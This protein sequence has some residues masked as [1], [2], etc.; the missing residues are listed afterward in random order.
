MPADVSP[1]SRKR[2]LQNT[3]VLKP[4]L[5]RLSETT[6]NTSTCKSSQE[7]TTEEIKSNRTQNVQ[8]EKEHP[9]PEKRQKLVQETEH[10][11][12][13]TYNN[14]GSPTASRVNQSTDGNEISSTSKTFTSPSAVLTC[15]N[16]H[17]SHYN[18]ISRN[19]MM[20]SP[21][22]DLVK[23]HPHETRRTRFNI[24]TGCPLQSLQSDPIKHQYSPLSH[25]PSTKNSG[26][27]FNGRDK[28]T[29]VGTSTDQIQ[30]E[31]APYLNMRQTNQ[32]RLLPKNSSFGNCGI[33]HGLSTYRT[34]YQAAP[35]FYSSSSSTALPT[36]GGGG[37]GDDGGGSWDPMKYS[38]HSLSHS[39]RMLKSAPQNSFVLPTGNDNLL[40]G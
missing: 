38:K 20:M 39:V 19:V 2:L 21:N 32:N 14:A 31:K 22:C 10:S 18:R 33:S 29:S 37:S 12:I 13:G 40:L 30:R 26:V 27:K 16:D 23:H 5:Q 8:A 11:T 17:P 24:I 6:S 4:H 9:S 1:K 35:G 25:S 34:S 28:I 3:T 36:G 7:E 15:N